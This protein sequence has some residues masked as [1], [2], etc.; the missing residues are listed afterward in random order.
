MAYVSVG[1]VGASALI[2]VAEVA[3]GNAGIQ[4][5]LYLTTLPG[6]V[7]LAYGAE[8]LRRRC[9]RTTLVIAASWTVAALGITSLVGLPV[10]S[11]SAFVPFAAAPLLLVPLPAIAAALAGSGD[12]GNWLSARG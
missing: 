11:D 2:A 9:G 6:L 7:G 5:W 8:R 3:S 1:V 4:S 10:Y 12:I